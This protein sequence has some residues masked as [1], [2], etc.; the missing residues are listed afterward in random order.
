MSPIRRVPSTGLEYPETMISSIPISL[1]FRT[2]I[3]SSVRLPSL[4]SALSVPIRLLNPPASTT[5]DTF[6]V[7]NATTPSLSA[8]GCTPYILKV[9]C[10][11]N[12]VPG[13]LCQGIKTTI[14]KER[15]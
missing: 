12:N 8:S 4:S 7:F 2:W 10:F 9:L 3:S 11:K 13:V 14:D 6:S 5:P 15:F 1:S